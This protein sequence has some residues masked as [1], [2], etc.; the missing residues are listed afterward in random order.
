MGFEGATP[1]VLRFWGAWVGGYTLGESAVR[2]GK[3]IN[4]GF[5]PL[6]QSEHVG[7]KCH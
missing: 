1:R 6:G 3:Y 7:R 4:P 5:Q 2:H